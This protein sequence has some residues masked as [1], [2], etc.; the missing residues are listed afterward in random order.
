[1]VLAQTLVVHEEVQRHRDAEEDE[2]R[3]AALLAI[4]EEVADEDVV[5]SE[6]EHMHPEDAQAASCGLSIGRVV[7]RLAR[8]GCKRVHLAR[9]EAEG[10]RV[11]FPPELN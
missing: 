6:R 11:F 9:R 5:E 1:M 7:A 4:E 3:E 10:F 8:V 2:A